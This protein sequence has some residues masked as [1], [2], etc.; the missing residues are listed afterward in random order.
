[1]NQLDSLTALNPPIGQ[2][3]YT[4]TLLNLLVCLIAAFI[5]RAV[6]VRYSRTLSGKFQVANILPLL[7]I[8][9]F[10]VI[11][12]VK[13]SL[14]LSLGLVG[15]LSIVR[16]RTP[17][18][19]PEELVYLFLAIALGLGYGANQLTIT[20]GV[21][22]VILAVIVFGLAR[23][24]NPPANQYNILV[25]W[26]D[27]DKALSD[28]VGVLSS[29]CDSSEL[30][31]YATAENEKSGFFRGVLPDVAAVESVNS[32]L[33]NLD[34]RIRVSLYETRPLQ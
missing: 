28:V 14:A 9:T 20:T 26:T 13:S 22:L 3:S 23:K 5:V 4:F 29:H 31:K 17:I 2:P 8:V 33:Q 32:T 6:Y 30:V 11:V 25:D 21:F 15:A 19:E 12:V 10:L 24:G 7:S 34:P 27:T 16:F 1:M 18:K